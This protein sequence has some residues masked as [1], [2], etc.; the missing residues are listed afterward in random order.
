MRRV[1]VTAS[2]E[3]FFIEVGAN[4]KIGMLL[5]SKIF[6]SR[7]APVQRKLNL[8]LEKYVR[9]HIGRAS[10]FSFNNV[11]NHVNTNSVTCKYHFFR[12]KFY[13]CQMSRGRICNQIIV[14]TQTGELKTNT[15][16]T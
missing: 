10:S 2:M 16:Y 15:D 14:T 3:Y 9:F 12:K 7:F 4:R 5:T 1:N 6:F 13:S 8:F 11:S